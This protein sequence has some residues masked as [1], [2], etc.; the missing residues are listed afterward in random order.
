M[1]TPSEGSSFT[2]AI[3]LTLVLTGVFT[4]ALASIDL[5]TIRQDWTNRR[6]D[7]SSLLLAGFLKPTDDT[8]SSLEFSKDNFNFCSDKIV[9]NV[10]KT[11]FAPF[12]AVLG[13]QVDSLNT[14]AGPM[15]NIRG[16]LKNTWGSFAKVLDKQFRQFSLIQATLYGTWA[17]L[18]AALQRVNAVV[19]STLYA[20][21]SINVLIQNLFQFIFK[22]ILIVLGVMVAL[23]ILLFFVLFP[24][25]PMIIT[26]IAVL[27]GV[28]GGAAVSGMAGAFCVDPNAK[29]KLFNGQTKKLKNLELG[30]RLYSTNSEKINKITG[31][32]TVNAKDIVL[33]SV[34]GILMSGSHRIKHNDIWILA[35][36]HPDAVRSTNKLETL[37][38]LNTTTHEVPVL[39][40]NGDLIFVG[41]WE[42]VDSEEGQHGWISMVNLQLNGGSI[43]IKEYPTAV[44][45]ASPNVKV[46]K[47]KEGLVPIEKIQIGDSILASQNRYTKVIGIYSGILEASKSVKDPEWISDGVW[48]KRG[49]RFWITSSS[50]IHHD[51]IDSNSDQVTHILYG[52]FLITEDETF[53][54]QNSGSLHCVRD[55][56]EIGASNIEKTYDILDILINKK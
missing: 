32:L 2:K 20:A 22:V 14:M 27:G 26:V 45:L 52:K 41:D 34:N 33:Y 37:I 23:I 12:Y 4:A 35:K 36:D 16:M 51:I 9:E 7:I 6:C 48:I 3:L 50:G 25:I 42:E 5:Q 1:E 28:L 44:P 19:F 40:S 10:L 53:M 29:I 55:F 8:R 47:E 39:G 13:K 43:S 56:T 17:K 54:I 49:E 31:I 15:N 24:F 46:F 18:K 21:L 38:C 30:D 11:A